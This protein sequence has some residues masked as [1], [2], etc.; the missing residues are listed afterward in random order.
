MLHDLKKLLFLIIIFI[1]V[2]GIGGYFFSGKADAHPMDISDLYFYYGKETD[3]TEIPENEMSGYL[4]INWYQAAALVQEKTGKDA[5]ELDMYELVKVEHDETYQSYIKNNLQLENNG[6]PCVLS[7][8]SLPQDETEFPLDL[9][10]R[11]IMDFKCEDKLSSLKLQNTLFLD[12]FQYSTNYVSLLRGDVLLDRIETNMY[13]KE[14]TFNIY[15]DGRAIIDKPENFT[16]TNGNVSPLDPS[17]NSQ[18]FGSA[19]IM[20]DKS[21]ESYLSR[22]KSFI[23]DIKRVGD[24]STMNPLYLIALLFLLGFLHT[25]E[26]GHSKVVLTSAML[27]KNM[28]MKGG[29]M[30][31]V[32][33]TVTHIG[34]ILLLGLSLLIINNFFDV[35]EKFALLEKAAI[36]CLLFIGV[37]LLF[38]SISDVVRKH[39]VDG[40]KKESAESILEHTHANGET[41]SHSHDFDPNKSFRD[42]LLVGFLTGLAPCVFGWSILMLIVSAKKIWLLIPAIL[43]FSLGIFCALL[44][45]VFL[46]GKFKK[47]IF[48]RLGWLTEISPI[49]SALILITYA[50][51]MIS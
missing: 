20:T 10:K 11:M 21:N 33:F 4:Y 51:Y 44:L 6:K 19:P 38:K 50:I 25:L 34:D 48:N 14:F 1:S 22:L 47:Q 17:Y 15:E 16:S 9:G 30:Y 12:K 42:Q 45:V 40:D 26:A 41:H 37:Y 31:A 27:H 18:N 43:S 35:Y 8:S 32:V 36:Y 2:L 28:T 49:L 39:F 29:V 5:L 46:I 13:L 23:A 7:F 24:V 3:N